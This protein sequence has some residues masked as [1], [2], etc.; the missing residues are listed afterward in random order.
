MIHFQGNAE[1]LPVIGFG[2]GLLFFF[3]G[4]RFYRETLVVADT[5][6]IPIRSVAMGLV[7]VQGIA[8]GDGAFPSPVSGLPCYAFKV[9]I[10]RWRQNSNRGGWSHYRTDVNGT[11]FYLEDDTG[12]A[13]VDPRGSELDLPKNCRRTVPE[14]LLSSWF[15]KEA[16][17]PPVDADAGANAI[18][19]VRSDDDL[20]EYAEG[21]GG[22]GS[23]RF[24]FTEYC[25][26][27][28]YQYDV[29]GTCVEN[30]HP[31]GPND[32][33]LIT[34]GQ[35]E[36]TYLISSKAAAQLER[37]LRWKSA[38]MVW[39]GVAL[40]TACAAFLLAEFGLL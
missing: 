19:E 34:K 16:D 33:N 6:A 10:E 40:A 13:Q 37:S 29:I 32:R 39:G 35:N 7:Q 30:P 8:K 15:D 25:V 28:G 31:S 23:N 17:L 38:L 24:R 11:R 27:P 2:A 14:S 36:R 20:L 26:C 4:L 22:M 21:V 12:R 1:L 18:P 3:R 5:P 9:E